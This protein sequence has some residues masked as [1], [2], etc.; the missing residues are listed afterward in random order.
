MSLR[1]AAVAARETAHLLQRLINGGEGRSLSFGAG[2][3]DAI[4]RGKS[5]RG[6]AA[7]IIAPTPGAEEIIGIALHAGKYPHVRST[8]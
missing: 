8:R 5:G 7:R 3:A 6:H 1:S 2:F 4:I